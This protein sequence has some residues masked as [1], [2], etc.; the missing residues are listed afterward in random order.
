MK[1]SKYINKINEF[2]RKIIYYSLFVALAVSI[3]IT[4]L[5]LVFSWPLT[6][7]IGFI[8]SYL[9]NIV[10][11]LK[12]NYVIDKILSGEYENPK[13]SMVLNNLTN[14]LIYGVIL[15][16]NLFITCFNVFVG[17][18]GLFIIKIVVIFGY[19]FKT[20]E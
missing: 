3:V 14:N 9:V 13:K 10:C 2:D 8:L 1:L 16:V 6:Y 18:V 19:G 5:C 11:F 7:L 4:I 17:L 20:K 15:C 12:S